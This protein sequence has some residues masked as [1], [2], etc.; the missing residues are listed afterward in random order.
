M[1]TLILNAGTL[2]YQTHFSVLCITNNKLRGHLSLPHLSLPHLS[3][4]P[5][6][7][8]VVLWYS[9]LPVMRCTTK[10]R[11]GWVWQAQGDE[12]WAPNRHLI[13]KELQ[14][15]ASKKVT[16]PPRT[17]EQSI[18]AHH[19]DSITTSDLSDGVVRVTFAISGVPPCLKLSHYI[20]G[21][22]GHMV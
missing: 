16:P 21:A 9:P 19:I 10:L 15:E 4:S 1:P 2:N 3:L 7:H 8:V 6:A 20:L 22:M 13:E 12:P 5:N 17:S 18:N 14:L 11:S